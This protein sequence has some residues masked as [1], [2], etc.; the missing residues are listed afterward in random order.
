MTSSRLDVRGHPKPPLTTIGEISEIQGI[1]RAHA[2][3]AANHFTRAGV[4]NAA[5]K[6][7]LG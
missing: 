5:S 2:M 3:K 4:F 7:R 6:I 1:A